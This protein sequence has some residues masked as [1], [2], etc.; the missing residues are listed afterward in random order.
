MEAI[1]PLED[2]GKN[3]W[4]IADFRVIMVAVDLGP[5]QIGSNESSFQLYP[6]DRRGCVWRTLGQSADPAFTIARHTDPQ[7]GVIVW[8][9]ISFDCRTPLV[10][11]RVHLQHSGMSTTI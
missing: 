9:A 10:I 3:G 5:Q 1:W 11:I 7:P 4:K 6:D 2:V 8:G